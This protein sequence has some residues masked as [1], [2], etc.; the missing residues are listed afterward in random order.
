ML[1]VKAVVSGMPVS[2][3][4]NASV[5]KTWKMLEGHVQVCLEINTIM[6]IT[7]QGWF[8]LLS[9]EWT[10]PVLVNDIFIPNMPIFMDSLL[11]INKHNSMFEQLLL[12]RKIETFTLYSIV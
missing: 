1:R 11:L 3:K 6:I 2:L 12:R 4:G 8:Y 10:G 9:V 7:L 5:I